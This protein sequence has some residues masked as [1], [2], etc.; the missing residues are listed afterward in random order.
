MGLYERDTQIFHNWCCPVFISVS[1]LKRM[2]LSPSLATVSG[3]SS[4]ATTRPKKKRAKLEAENNTRIIFCTLFF[5]ANAIAFSYTAI[6]W[7]AAVDK[8]PKDK[9]LSSWAPYAKVFQQTS[10]S[11]F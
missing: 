2:S 4:S 3:E 9:K 1:A 6:I 10:T 8:L 7:T 11:V 5:L